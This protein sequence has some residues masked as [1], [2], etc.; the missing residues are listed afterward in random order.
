[1]LSINNI[2]PFA[3]SQ[4]QYES[5]LL[6]KSGESIATGYNQSVGVIED[7]IGSSEND[8]CAIARSTLRAT[9]NAT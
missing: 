7:L 6:Q 3:V 2:A 1:M 9:I 5:R 8:T 4:A